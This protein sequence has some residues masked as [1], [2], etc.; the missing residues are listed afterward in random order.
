M[1]QPQPDSNNRPQ[2]FDR[3][4]LILIIVAST[5]AIIVL[6]SVLVYCCLRAQRRSRRLERLLLDELE[7]S[8]QA[9]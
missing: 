2:G 3:D 1:P 8:S 7:R 5:A 9:A 6:M 4:T